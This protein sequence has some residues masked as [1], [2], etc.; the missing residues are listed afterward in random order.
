MRLWTDDDLPDDLIRPEA[1]E[2][3]RKPAERSDIIRLE[4]LYRF[5][6]V[7][8]DTDIECL[9]PL[10]PLIEG[11]DFFTCDLKPGQV[12]NAAIGSVPGHPILERALRELKPR[13]EFGYDKAGT[14]PLFLDRVVREH[15][16]VTIFPPEI[17]YPGSSDEL[18]RAYAVHHAARS[19]KE[20]DSWKETALRTERRLRDARRRIEKLERA[21]GR[22]RLAPRWLRR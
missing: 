2:R 4:V 18:E 14:G 9:R 5:G 13:S 21:A 15:G 12:N 16:G 6:G 10:D 22:R 8:V 19:W 3:L 1:Y 11:L 7:Y 20:P 17:F